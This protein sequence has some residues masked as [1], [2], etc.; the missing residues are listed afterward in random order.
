MKI[1]HPCLTLLLTASLCI[2]TPWA[3]AQPCSHNNLALQVLGTGGTGPATRAGSS[4]LLWFDGK[5]RLLI[6]AGDGSALRFAESGARAGDLDAVLFTTLLAGHSAGLPAIVLAARHEARTR[7]LPVFGPPGG[8]GMP[9]TVGFVRDLFDSTRG[10]WRHLGEHLAPLAKGV[11][12]LDPHDVRDTP[13][14]LGAAR[15]P[16]RAI[17]PVPVGERFKVTALATVHDNVP[18][19][20]WRIEAGGKVIVLADSVGAADLLAPLVQGAQ[21]LVVQEI[22]DDGKDATPEA[23]GRLA[24]NARVGQLIVAQRRGQAAREDALLASLRK[25]YAGPVALADDLACFI[26]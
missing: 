22:A 26:P 23:I 19:L 6:D 5:A 8:R 14:H 1:P 21:L 20:A 4:S 12:K 25:A 15:E 3:Q 9:S 18:A 7:R 2:A 24:Q 16:R 11:Y 13:P 10:A 17:L